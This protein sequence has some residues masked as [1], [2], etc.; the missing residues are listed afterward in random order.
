MSAFPES[1][2]FMSRL[3]LLLRNLGDVE[4]LLGEKESATKFTVQ[5]HEVQQAFFRA[6]SAEEPNEVTWRV[7]LS[8]AIAAEARVWAVKGDWSRS[9]DRLNAA[10]Q[11]LETIVASEPNNHFWIHRLALA[12]DQLK[13]SQFNVAHLAGRI[14]LPEVRKTQLDADIRGLE[15]RRQLCEMTTGRI[16]AGYLE[17]LDEH[18]EGILPSSAA[19]S[20]IRLRAR[21]LGL[22]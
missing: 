19:T 21:L 14:D 16:R 6:R 10:V 5:S 12:V 17:R 2:R 9:R 22:M 4:F 3:S 7:L 15:L 11:E 13:G 18:Y 1:A 20:C 8:D